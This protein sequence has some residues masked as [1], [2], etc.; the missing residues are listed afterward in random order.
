M[1]G[2]APGLGGWA[3]VRSRLPW[4]RRLVIV[5][6]LL[7]IVRKVV[8]MPV[9]V[10]GRSMLPAL[11]PGQIVGVNKLAYR[12]KPPNRG[13]LV[14]FSTGQELFIKRIV[15]LPG[16]EISVVKGIICVDGRPLSESYPCSTDS[17][18]TIGPGIIGGDQFVVMGDNRPES[19][20]AVVNRER[21]VGRLV[22]WGKR[23]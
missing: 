12:R 6:S 9:L 16:E 5:L 22:V 20:I 19:L 21:I 11:R 14:L 7:S 3:G 13:D 17:R 23:N 8:W 15:G 10:E 1:K 18:L 2:F 4:F